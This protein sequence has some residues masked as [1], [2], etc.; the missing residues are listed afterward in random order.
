VEVPGPS[1]VGSDSNRL[2]FTC[3]LRVPLEITKPSRRNVFATPSGYFSDWIAVLCR[4]IAMGEHRVDS[5]SLGQD[6]AEP[7]ITDCSLALSLCWSPRTISVPE[8]LARYPRHRRSGQ[9]YQS[10]QQSRPLS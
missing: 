9:K 5:K 6:I 8:T 2:G 1:S 7:P 4:T 10:E 3:P